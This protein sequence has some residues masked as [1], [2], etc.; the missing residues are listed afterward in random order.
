[1][2]CDVCG[3][4]R[5][6]VS[7][8][9]EVV[10]LETYTCHVCR[11]AEECLECEDTCRTCTHVSEDGRDV[12]CNRNVSQQGRTPGLVS[13]GFGCLYHQPRRT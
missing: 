9:M 5:P 12:W 2:T 4:D 11:Y 10:G 7:G 6:C 13:S 3:Y 1:M 8:P